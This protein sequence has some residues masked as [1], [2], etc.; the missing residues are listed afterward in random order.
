MLGSLLYRYK[1]ATQDSEWVS[2]ILKVEFLD[3]LEMAKQKKE[4]SHESVA[5]DPSRELTRDI[6]REKESNGRE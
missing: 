4:T 5:H 6:G 2:D 3:E 1:G